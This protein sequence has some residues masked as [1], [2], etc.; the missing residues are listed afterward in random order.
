M[1][2]N[3]CTIYVTEDKYIPFLMTKTSV[4]ERHFLVIYITWTQLA[5]LTGM[6]RRDE[7]LDGAINEGSTDREAG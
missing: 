4:S 2:G 6:V 1:S 7:I 3:G 5:L